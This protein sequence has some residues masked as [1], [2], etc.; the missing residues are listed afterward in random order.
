MNATTSN[1]YD[2]IK[3][4]SEV[5]DATFNRAVAILQQR[6]KRLGGVFKQPSKASSEIK[7]GVFILK[8]LRGEVGRFKLSDTWVNP[9]LTFIAPQ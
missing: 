5:F 9:G 6:S 3:S 1:P 7:D 2:S 8:N 4:S